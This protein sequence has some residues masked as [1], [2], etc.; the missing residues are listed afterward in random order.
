MYIS[1]QSL[2]TPQKKVLEKES[3]TYKTQWVS[4]II[5]RPIAAS[6]YAVL[7][8]G[9]EPFQGQLIRTSTFHG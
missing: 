4:Y 8:T 6:K 9:H 5:C 3:V 2:K 1:N 7:C